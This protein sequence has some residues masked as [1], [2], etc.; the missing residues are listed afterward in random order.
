M[1]WTVRILEAQVPNGP[2]TFDVVATN[3]APVPYEN[4]DHLV[5]SYTNRLQALVA[6]RQ[7]ASQHQVEIHQA[8]V[9]PFARARRA[10]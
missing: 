2:T 3:N 4:P 10:A 9:I 7:F 1:R 8:E 6:A 5:A